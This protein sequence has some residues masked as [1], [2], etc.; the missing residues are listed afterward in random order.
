[1]ETKFQYKV[2]AKIEKLQENN[3]TGEG[4]DDREF[5]EAIFVGDNPESLREEAINR[6][7]SWEDILLQ[8]EQDDVEN[9]VGDERGVSQSFEINVWF[10]DPRDGEDMLIHKINSQLIG[11]KAGQLNPID[12]T[13]VIDGLGREFCVLLDLGITP[14]KRVVLVHPAEPG[15]EFSNEIMPT[16][17]FSNARNEVN[18]NLGELL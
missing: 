18:A 1:M 7:K 16:P 15:E 5:D 9:Y 11:S 13:N 4:L 14:S 8:A 2:T 10:T 12:M 3:E 17:Y 6:A